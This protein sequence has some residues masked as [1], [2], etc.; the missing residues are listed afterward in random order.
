M[1]SLGVTGSIQVSLERLETFI[2]NIRSKSDLPVSLGFGIKN[3]EN[4]RTMR[5]YADGVI[6]GTSIVSLTSSGN[7][8]YTINEINNFFE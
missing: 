4:V 1:G 8:E 6:I 5:K 2:G 7:L 3:N